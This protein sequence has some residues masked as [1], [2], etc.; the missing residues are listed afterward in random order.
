M[1]IFLYFLKYKRLIIVQI[2]LLNVGSYLIFLIVL[3]PSIKII[4]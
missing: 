2:Q 4:Q 1:F 3:H